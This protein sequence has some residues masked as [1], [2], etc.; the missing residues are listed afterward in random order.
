MFNLFKTTPAVSELDASCQSFL[1]AYEKMK[2]LRERV[3]QISRQ[4][5]PAQQRTVEKRKERDRVKTLYLDSLTDTA[6]LALDEAELALVE[7]RNEIASLIDAQKSLYEQIEKQ[8]EEVGKVAI[9]IR[10]LA[11]KAMKDGWSLRHA[12]ANGTDKEINWRESVLL[13]L[14]RQVPSVNRSAIRALH[15]FFQGDRFQAKVLRGFRVTKVSPASEVWNDQLERFVPGDPTLDVQLFNK[16]TVINV[17][18]DLS[19]KT[20]YDEVLLGRLEVVGA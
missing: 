7:G 14:L 9:S 18:G 1:D 13:A 6:R 5:G 17:P 3:G 11:H 2:R 8:S 12:W 16:D 15:A 10:D 4:I 20:A 19:P